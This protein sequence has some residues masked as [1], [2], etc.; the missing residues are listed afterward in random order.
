MYLHL[1]QQE[2]E[3]TTHATSKEIMENNIPKPSIFDPKSF[4]E[5]LFNA[6]EAEIKVT[7][8]SKITSCSNIE[9]KL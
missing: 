9:S 6:R 1:T 2:S 5:S 3:E 7:R 8:Q 4:L